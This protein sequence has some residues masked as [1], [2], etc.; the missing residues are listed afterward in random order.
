MLAISEGCYIYDI[1]LPTGPELRAIPPA[2]RT[3]WGHVA[4]TEEDLL[5]ASDEFG[6][7]S[8]F[9]IHEPLT[10]TIA[11]S[12]RIDAA[13]SVVTSRDQFIFAPDWRQLNVIAISELSSTLATTTVLPLPLLQ[14]PLD[15]ATDGDIVAL[16]A[17][18]EGVILFDVSN[19][20]TP[21][22]T[23]S[24]TDT[25]IARTVEISGSSLFVG[26]E[27]DRV[28]SFN[29]DNAA[30]P[31]LEDTLAVDRGVWDFAM[32]S[33]T[34]IVVSPF[35]GVQVVDVSETDN[36]SLLDDIGPDE[37]DGWNVTMGSAVS[38]GGLLAVPIID[39]DVLLIDVTDPD[40][41][42]IAGTVEILAPLGCVFDSDEILWITSGDAIYG[43]QVDDPSEPEMLG[44][45]LGQG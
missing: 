16:A 44:Q 28:Q 2:F 3:W 37:E 9:D 18:E 26:W 1:A 5:I 11:S 39:G 4:M 27:D 41:V 20:L 19:P 24:I 17:G 15:I 23:A 45:V 32:Y 22:F 29:V 42:T 34:L 25:A 6:S 43:M 30:S 35:R 36:M 10:P 33:H 40:D 21:T 12:I 13:M 8:T 31:V 7:I 14:P 38:E